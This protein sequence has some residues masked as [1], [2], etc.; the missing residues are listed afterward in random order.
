MTDIKTYKPKQMLDKVKK[1][2]N[3]NEPL[4]L[5]AA[6]DVQGVVINEILADPTA[7]GGSFDTNGDGV[8]NTDDEFIELYNTTGSQVDIGGWTITD[9]SGGTFTFPIGATIPANGYVTIV[10][11]WNGPLPANTYEGLPTLNDGSEVITLS[12]GTNDAIAAYGS[13]APTSGGDDFGTADDALSMSRVPDC[14][15]K[16]VACKV[17]WNPICRYKE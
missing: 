7:P 16:R 11:D 5:I 1:S 9:A 10:M 14:I 3:K 17:G 13:G 8:F 6:Q 15:R 12:D 2:V 4:N